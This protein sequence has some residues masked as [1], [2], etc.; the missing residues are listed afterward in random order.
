MHS[1]TNIDSNI[2]FTGGTLIRLTGILILHIWWRIL[3]CMHSVHILCPSERQ[4]HGMVCRDDVTISA[5]DNL[6]ATLQGSASGHVLA[7]GT[8]SERGRERSSS[9]LRST[10]F[11]PVFV[12]SWS[13]PRRNPRCS[14]PTDETRIRLRALH[15]KT[16][17]SFHRVYIYSLR[18]TN[19]RTLRI[20]CTA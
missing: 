15:H 18:S 10:H 5:T 20:S 3:E 19:Y 9:R 6:V 12:L 1:V 8:W 13:P 2:S 7:A 16:T 14:L 11:R 4:G 17:A